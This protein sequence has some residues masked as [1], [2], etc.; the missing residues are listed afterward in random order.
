[1]KKLKYILFGLFFVL[2]SIALADGPAKTIISKVDEDNK[3]ISG[4]TPSGVQVLVYIDDKYYG[5]AQVNDSGTET[6]NFYFSFKNIL[7]EGK[8]T[9]S[10]FTRD[11]E[12]LLLSTES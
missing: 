6:D 4:L 7:N 2:P 3:I 12:T 1:M 5:V 9:A 10:V 11:K 8:H